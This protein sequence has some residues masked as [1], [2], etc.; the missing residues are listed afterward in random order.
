MDEQPQRRHRSDDTLATIAILGAVG[1]V[2]GIAL[3]ITLIAA[4]AG[5][6]P[7]S[8]CGSA[9]VVRDAGFDP[10]TGQP[11]GRVIQ[12]WCIDREYVTESPVPNERLGRTGLP[13]GSLLVVG[14]A[15]G[16]L[17]VGWIVGASTRRPHGLGTH[18][19][20]TR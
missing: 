17:V 20:H 12:G 4:P 9:T 10:W 16:G 5:V 13:W 7:T 15:L 19:R 1:A 2:A 18:P 3:A 8:G 14:F 11:Q 6:A